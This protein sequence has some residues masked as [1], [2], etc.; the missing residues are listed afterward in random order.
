MLAFEDFDVKPLCKRSQRVSYSVKVKGGEALPSFIRFDE[1]QRQF[2]V[3]NAENS[4]ANLEIVGDRVDPRMKI[5]SF[6]LLR[7]GI[8]RIY[9]R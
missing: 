1:D 2:T 8:Y 4:P 3:S 6:C 7:L 9:C 5:Y